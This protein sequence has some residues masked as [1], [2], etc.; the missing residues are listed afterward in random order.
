MKW[1]ELWRFFGGYVM[2]CVEGPQLEKF[3][4]LLALEGPKVWHVVRGG[5]RQ[6]TFATRG[7]HAK[8]IDE[9]CEKS[10]C[11]VTG[12]THRGLPALLSPLKRRWALSIG[13]LLI[14]AAII[15][16]GQFVWDIDVSGCP[17]QVRD[18]ILASLESYGARQGSYKGAIDPA[19]LR[20]RLLIDYPQMTWMSVSIQGV[21]MR[22]EAVPRT[23]TPDIL[24]LHGQ[25]DIVALKGGRVVHVIPLSGTP[26]VAEGELVKAGQ[27]LIEGIANTARPDLQRSVRAAGSVIANVWYRGQASY[28]LAELS[29]M[30][31]GNVVQ[32]RF[33]Q[34]GNIHIPLSEWTDQPFETMETERMTS[35][36]PGPGFFLPVQIVTEDCYEI[37]Q[38]PEALDMETLKMDL[39]HEARQ[40]AL[41]QIPEGAQIVDEAVRFSQSDQI[42][43]ARVALTTREDIAK[44]K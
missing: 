39:A 42:L 12:V 11:R 6:I 37:L 21:R 20:D 16:A 29:K 13:L 23:E 27:L 33:M 35:Y 41:V 3:I 8:R 19:T 40:N 34:M 9:L 4:N 30:R 17:V 1:T 10:L 24:N 31:S 18:E 25:A 14:A 26:R 5:R 15:A 43:T 2:I 28:D 44:E 38:M 7:R 36:I 32:R 22:V